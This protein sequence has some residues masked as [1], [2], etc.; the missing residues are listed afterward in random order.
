MQRNLRPPVFTGMNF[1]GLPHFLHAGGG[2][3]LAMGARAGSGGS[4]KLSVTDNCRSW[5]MM[6]SACTLR[7]E[8]SEGIPTGVLLRFMFQPGNEAFATPKLDCAA[9]R[10]SFSFAD[11]I[12]VVSTV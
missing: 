8:N 1:I 4:T 6:Y 10:Q 5:A 9:I 3:F 11:C 7:F 2:V 12:M